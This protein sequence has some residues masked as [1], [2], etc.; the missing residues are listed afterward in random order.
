MEN[1]DQSQKRFRR[2]PG[3]FILSGIAIILIA[4]FVYVLKEATFSS[5]LE[6][7]VAVKNPTADAGLIIVLGSV[8][9]IGVILISV[10]LFIWGKDE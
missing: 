10:G 7:Y 3:I 2:M 8:I 5:S 1:H 6:N 4:F 9:V